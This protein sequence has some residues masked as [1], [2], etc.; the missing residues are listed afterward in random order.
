MI[1]STS[2]RLKTNKWNNS[3]QIN[4]YKFEHFKSLVESY[5]NNEFNNKYKNYLNLT[6]PYHDYFHLNK[7]NNILN[8]LIKD[9]SNDNIARFSNLVFSKFM[10]L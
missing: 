1:L 4:A 10:D 2:N 8:S 6:Y 5:F 3:I 7:I 9:Y